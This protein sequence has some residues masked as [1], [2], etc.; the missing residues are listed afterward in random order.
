L[1]FGKVFIFGILGAFWKTI[2][3]KK[4]Q[5]DDKRDNS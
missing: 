5:E 4:K 3:G 2:I 1:K